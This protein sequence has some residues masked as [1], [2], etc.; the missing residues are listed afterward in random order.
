MDSSRQYITVDEW[1]A[2]SLGMNCDRFDLFAAAFLASFFMSDFLII[3]GR[4][5]A[6][7]VKNLFFQCKHIMA[8]QVR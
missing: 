5:P 1:K 8:V 4:V 6:R 3:P 7:L 2:Q